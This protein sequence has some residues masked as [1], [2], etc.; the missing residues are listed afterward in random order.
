MEFESPIRAVDAE[1]NLMNM[2]MGV[3]LENGRFY[4]LDITNAKNTPENKRVIAS[5]PKEVNV[6]KI[7]QVRY[8]IGSGQSSWT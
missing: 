1:S 6:G 2:L 8:K 7:I 3:G 4:V 5:S